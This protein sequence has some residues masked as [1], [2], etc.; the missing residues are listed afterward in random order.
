MAL[1]KLSKTDKSTVYNVDKMRALLLA[2]REL[3]IARVV[4]LETFLEIPNEA[5][6]LYK[7]RTKRKEHANGKEST[8]QAGG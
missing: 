7:H 8:G 3:A 4:A 5:S 6:A 1:E 2:E